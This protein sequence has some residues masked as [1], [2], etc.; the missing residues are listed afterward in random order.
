MANQPMD[1]TGAYPAN[2]DSNHKTV[3]AQVMVK[4][5]F[6]DISDSAHATFAKP[7][8][9]GTAWQPSMVQIRMRDG[10]VLSVHH[11]VALQ[12]VLQGVATL[13]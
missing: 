10:R 8:S 4:A 12:R 13:V 2:V 9:A 5:G 7:N 11:E 1:K 6:V 3:Q